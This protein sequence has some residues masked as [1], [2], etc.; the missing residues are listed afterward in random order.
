MRPAYEIPVMHFED[1]A[2]TPAPMWVADIIAFAV[3]LGT[4]GLIIGAAV[5]V[6][7]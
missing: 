6:A 7:G 3:V 5:A 2:P 4:G 1:N